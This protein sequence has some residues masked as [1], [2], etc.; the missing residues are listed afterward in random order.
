MGYLGSVSSSPSSSPHG[1]NRFF[2]YTS[3]PDPFRLFFSV[4]YKT[5]IIPWKKIIGLLFGRGYEK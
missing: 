1:S 3:G 4:F 5:A 2:R